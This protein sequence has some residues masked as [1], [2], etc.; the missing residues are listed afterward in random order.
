MQILELS[1]T[2]MNII[3]I[4]QFKKIGDKMENFS[5]KPGCTKKKKKR[6]RETLDQKNIIT[7]NKN[8]VNRVES[9]VDQAEQRI[10][11]WKMNEREKSVLYTVQSGKRRTNTK[12]DDER[13]KNQLKDLKKKC[14][15]CLVMSNSL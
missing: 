2:D 8:S 1:D 11:N 7:E 3:V 15:S 9:T 10:N 14:V 12:K 4:S 5:Q 13:H 6:Q